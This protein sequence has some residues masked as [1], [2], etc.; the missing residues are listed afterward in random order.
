M[1]KVKVAYG[2]SPAEVATKLLAAAE[3]LDQPGGVVKT[4]SDGH[5][6]VPKEVA[7][8]AGLKPLDEEVV[9]V[10]PAEPAAPD[11][12]RAT[13]RGAPPAPEVEGNDV[14]QKDNASTAAEEIPA[15]IAALKGKALSKALTEA[16]LPDKGKV[17]EKR[18]ALAQHRAGKA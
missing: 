5:F 10:V 16:G 1:N 14:E 2:D 12:A 6:V 15:D 17:D 18:A 3:R 8:E 9:E 7:D 4:T 13:P 11:T